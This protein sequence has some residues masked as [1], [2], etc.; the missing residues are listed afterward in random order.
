MH[1]GVRMR[2]HRKR[3]NKKVLI[4]KGRR[5]GST[6]SSFGFRPVMV[7]LWG[8]VGMPLLSTLNIACRIEF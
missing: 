6:H 7:K 2:V 1:N 3:R 4:P 8:N 5:K